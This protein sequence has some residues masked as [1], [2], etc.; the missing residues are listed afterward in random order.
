MANFTALPTTLTASS[1]SATDAFDPF[2][3]SLLSNINDSF[4]PSYDFDSFPTFEDP[5]SYQPHPLISSA[6]H[7]HQSSSILN[8]SS[9]SSTTAASSIGLLPEPPDISLLE[10]DDTPPDAL[11][12][13]LLS[14]SAPIPGKAALVDE[15]GAIIEPNMSAELYGM[16]FVAEDVF[17]ATEHGRPLELTCYRRNLW[18]CSGV[19]SV[20]RQVCG[21]VDVESGR[22]IESADFVAGISA[23]ESIEGK[24]TEIITIPWKSGTTEEGKGTAPVA[25][26]GSV[27]VEFEGGGGEVV[28]GWKRLQFKHATANNGRRKGL[29]QHYVVVV[30]LGVRAGG[31]VV[32][33][34]EVRSGPVIVRGRSPRNFDSKRDVPLTGERIKERRVENGRLAAGTQQTGEWPTTPNPFAAPSTTS[35]LPPNKKIAVSP[36]LPRPP[37]PSWDTMATTNN[38]RK[39]TN[40]PKPS[41]PTSSIPRTAATLP[42]NLSLSEDERSPN[43]SSTSGDGIQSPQFMGMK[44]LG[45]AQTATGQNP[46]GSPLESADLLYEYFPLSLDDW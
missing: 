12:N 8:D 4:T 33:V 17:G 44:S 23:V 36:G 5:F 39:F 6:H 3:E 38:N 7:G 11:D 40:P 30:S 31:E 34:A 42:I 46:N 27:G 18:Q 32:R 1:A 29:Q 9:I 15:H 25:A 22:R 28:V 2:D 43:K 24:A 41:L 10:D 19:V 20:P 35:N 13:K 37:V 14:F 21:V 16:F 45:G 26:P